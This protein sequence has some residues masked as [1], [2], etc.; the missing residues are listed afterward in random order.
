MHTCYVYWAELGSSELML[1]VG[2]GGR[3]ELNRDL[4]A[5]ELIER[6]MHSAIDDGTTEVSTEYRGLLGA[7]PMPSW[8]D[9]GRVVAYNPYRS[10]PS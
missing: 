5:V 7:I 3:W 1:Q 2:E 9:R 6:I 8:K 4:K 10:R